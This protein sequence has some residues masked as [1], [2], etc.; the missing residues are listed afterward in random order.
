LDNQ[1]LTNP[2]DGV[3]IRGFALELLQRK[4]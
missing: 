1:V 2:V 4:R 3:N